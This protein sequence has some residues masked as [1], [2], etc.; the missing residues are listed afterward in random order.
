MSSPLFPDVSNVAID[1]SAAL[2]S[3]KAIP[4]LKDRAALKKQ[5]VWMMDNR[6]DATATAASNKL[7][8]RSLESG[9]FM[10]WTL[11]AYFPTI[12]NIALADTDNFEPADTIANH[13]ATA[14]G[15]PAKDANQ[16]TE[17]AEVRLISLFIAFAC[18]GKSN[19]T[20]AAGATPAV[21][22]IENEALGRRFKAMVA[23]KRLP[24]ETNGVAVC[25]ALPMGALDNGQRMIWANDTIAKTAIGWILTANPSSEADKA[26]IQQMKMIYGGAEM[27]FAKT[28][29][30]FLQQCNNSLLIMPLVVEEAETMLQ[31]MEELKTKH[32][33]HHL[34][35]RLL[36]HLDADRLAPNAFP[37]LSGAVTF[38]INKRNALLTS[39][40][41]ATVQQ[42]TLNIRTNGYAQDEM[43]AAYSTPL[44][45]G[46]KTGYSSATFPAR[47][48]KATGLQ[49]PTT[50]QA[51]TSSVGGGVTATN[52]PPQMVPFLRNLGINIP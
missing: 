19:T 34:H 6:L 27:T 41:T 28:V 44:P 10:I 33:N 20:R 32:N 17:T 15:L 18:L 39:G 30:D 40:T 11:C 4:L 29:T 8:E 1:D 48:Q 36:H 16:V 5:V 25:H 24:S 21:R 23:G 43:Q 3:P 37:Y 13:L 9:E 52:I 14:G 26:L 45:H 22:F 47:F 12:H 31:V 46:A 7:L 42:A 49:Q 50:P 35:L 38:W 2:Y 51:S